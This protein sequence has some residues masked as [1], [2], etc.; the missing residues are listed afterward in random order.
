MW[1]PTGFNI[2]PQFILYINNM[3]NIS[4]LVKF[5]DDTNIFHTNSYISRL[6]ETISCVLENYA[7]GL[8]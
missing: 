6:K 3:C 5:A 4:N 1:C 2:G 7:Y 8:Q